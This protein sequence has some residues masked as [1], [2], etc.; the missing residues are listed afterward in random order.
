MSRL[1]RSSYVP[2]LDPPADPVTRVRLAETAYVV[3]RVGTGLLFLCHG[4]Q[5]LFGLFGG[6]VVPLASQMGVAGLL[7]LVGGL[8]LV[9]GFFVRPV[10]AVLALEMLVAYVMAHLPRSPWPLEN[11]GEVAVLYFV[12]F[13]FL[14]L[15]PRPSR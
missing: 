4:L 13:V 5:K 3:L 12:V 14:A 11:G 9:L 8:L 15:M 10:A 1:A 7:E 2:D 6:T